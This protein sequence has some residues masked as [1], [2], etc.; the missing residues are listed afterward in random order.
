MVKQNLLSKVII[1]QKNEVFTKTC[2]FYFTYY[3]LFRFSFF[4]FWRFNIFKQEAQIGG[5]ALDVKTKIEFI[6]NYPYQSLNDYFKNLKAVKTDVP[7]ISK[8][9]IGRESLF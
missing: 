1:F 6:D 3:F 5:S 2:K 7:S 4:I 8:E 9:E